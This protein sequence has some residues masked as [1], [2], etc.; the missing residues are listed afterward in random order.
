MR[1]E[2]KDRE[3][4]RR[5]SRS[6]VAAVAGAAAAA[7]AA[8]VAVTLLVVHPGAG[9]AASAADCA[10]RPPG[11][12]W[13]CLGEGFYAPPVD[14]SCNLDGLGSAG[15]GRPALACASDIHLSQAIWMTRA[16]VYVFPGSASV[17]RLKDGT[18]TFKVLRL[19]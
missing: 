1:G 13:L 16:R 14:W 10:H 5:R 15:T 11:A 19:P 4:R 2:E 7:S 6:V 9:R 8:S 3:V 17:R 12:Q 18:Y